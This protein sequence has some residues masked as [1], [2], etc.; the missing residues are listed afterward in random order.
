MIYQFLADDQTIADFAENNADTN[1]FK[2]KQKLTCQT[3]DNG[4]KNVKTIVPLKNLNN[5]WRTLEMLSVNCEI[6]LDLNGSKRCIIV[7]NNAG[8]RFL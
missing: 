3:G 5:F 8:Q 7:T 1:S 6:N 2:I 4:T